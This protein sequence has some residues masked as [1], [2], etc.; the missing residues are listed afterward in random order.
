MSLVE[1]H[2]IAKIEGHG[3]L[4]IAFKECR[5]KLEI[6]EGERLFEALL[7]NR[8]YHDGPFIT[9]RICGVCPV[10]HTIASIKAIEDALDIDVNENII[11]LRKILLASQ[12]IQSHVLHLFFLTLPDYLGY[13]SVLELS[14]NKPELFNMALELKASADEITTII[15]GRN[16][17][18]INAVVGGFS[19]P[20][21][22]KQLLKIRQRSLKNLSN[23][24]KTV[25]I[26]NQFKYPKITNQTL[27]MALVNGKEYEMY[28][29]K[30]EVSDNYIFD[31]INYKKEIQEKTKVYSTAKFSTYDKKT[32]MVGA[33]ARI[34]LHRDYL[35]N[36]AKKTLS[37]INF[38]NF[39]PFYNNLAQAIE[40]V[41]LLEEII[42]LCDKLLQNKDF[43]NNLKVDFNI[44]AGKGV[45]AIEAP[46]GLLYHYYELD[47]SGLI[48]NCDIITPTAQNLTN[49]END[50]SA[51]LKKFGQRSKSKNVC[52][53][54]LEMLIRAYDPCITCSVH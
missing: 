3:V 18:P 54:E 19:A 52:I 48:I 39:N 20:I 43:P 38:P 5:A 41:H 28:D 7:L 31:P 16:V 33:I 30:I 6:H 27:Y 21:S 14:K 32:F 13:N 4:N 8:P 17:H 44:K 36:H 12:I 47:K 46:R 11:N 25:E 23:A 26:F 50:A 9:S 10:A 15:G 29:G 53:R 42:K 45:G 2:Y 49:I 37:K 24:Q 34:A 40:N 1:E 22:K 35:N 51:L